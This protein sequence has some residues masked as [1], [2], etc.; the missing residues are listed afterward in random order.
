[1]NVL[2]IVITNIKLN[3]DNFHYQT[4]AK[5]RRTSTCTVILF[6]LLLLCGD[7]E[8]NPGPVQFPC[9]VC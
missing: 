5:Y 3:Y 8:S 4:Y 9:G 7:I 6:M 1:M 2:S